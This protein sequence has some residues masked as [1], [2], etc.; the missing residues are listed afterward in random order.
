MKEVWK[1][2]KGYEGYQISNLGRVKSLARL[3]KGKGNGMLPVPERIL[4]TDITIKGENYK[5]VRVTLAENGRGKHFSLNV[6][7][8]QAFSEI[9][10]EWFEGA[11]VHH[12]NGNPLDNRAENLIVL[13]P[14][15]HEKKHIGRFSG[16]KNP[17]Y[18]KHHNKESMD[19]MVEKKSKPVLQYS[20]DGCFIREW[21]SATEVMRVLGIPK[22]CVSG[23]CLGRKKHKT[24]GGFIWRFKQAS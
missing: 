22:N 24:A 1:N 14:E 10:G 23:C 7:V 5:S 3:K 17:F 6:L 21:H 18:G 16:E 9:C 11:E 20:L 19:R 4:K 12:I 8:A 13:S 15:E 2:I